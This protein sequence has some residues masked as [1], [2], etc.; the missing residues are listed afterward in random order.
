LEL[1]SSDPLC[2]S[3]KLCPKLV[4]DGERLVEGQHQADLPPGTYQLTASL[5]GFQTVERKGLWLPFGTTLTVDIPLTV[6]KA[7]TLTVEGK[8]PTVDVTTAQSTATVDKDLIVSLPLFSNQRESNT[9]FELSPGSTYQAA[10][11]GGGNNL[12]IDGTPATMSFG[13]S[14]NSVTISPNWLEEVN[15]VALGANAEYGDF[16]GVTP[17]SWCGAGATSSMGCLDTGRPARTG[18]ATT[19]AASQQACA[20]VSRPTRSS[21]AG[22]RVRRPAVLS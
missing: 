17:T 13:Q 14:A 6:G 11:G 10:Y 9:I 15:V 16:A 7:E 4:H 21:P 2:R 12:M 18:S 19:R 20:R 8:T 3:P 1:K 5:T 22:T